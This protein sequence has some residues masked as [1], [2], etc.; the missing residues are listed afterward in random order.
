MR[1]VDVIVNVASR[2]IDKPF[3]YE[4]PA[5]DEFSHLEIGHLVEV[6]FGNRTVPGFVVDTD[7]TPAVEGD[8]K[9]IIQIISGPHFGS[10]AV[11]IAQ[12][13]SDYYAS[14]LANCLNLFTPPLGRNWRKPPKRRPRIDE[15]LPATDAP[16]HERLTEG[17]IAA[18]D[19]IKTLAGGETLL[20]DG[21]T[22][23]GKT[24][25]YLR[26]IEELI[27][28]GKSAIVLVPEISL[29]PQTVGRFRARFGE[30]VAVLH[31]RLTEAQRAYQLSRLS[32]GQSCVVVGPR[33]ALFA[34]LNN[35]GMIVIDEE[36]DGSYK[37][38]SDP[39]YHARKVAQRIA[40][41]TGA[42]VVLG[43]ATPSFET[44]AQ[45]KEGRIAMVAL[46]E[47][48]NAQPLPPVEV[49]DMTEEFDAGNRSMFSRSLQ[50]HLQIVRDE[51]KKAIILLNRRGFAN[52]V[53]CRECGYVP[54]CPS[55]A[56]S[57]TLHA[58]HGRLQCHHCGRLEAMPPS[59]P[60]CSSPYIASFGAGTQKVESELKKLFD[61]WPV[62]RMDA[63]TTSARTGHL[64]QLTA[65]ESLASGVLVGT[66]MIA[67][68]LDYPDV[69]LVGIIAADSSLNIPEYTAAERTYQ[70]LE[71]V[72]GRAGRAEASGHVI[73]QTYQPAH[74]S[75][76]AVTKHDRSVVL[77]SELSA[78]QELGYPPFTTMANVVI[79]SLDEKEAAR[80][81]EVIGDALKVELPPSMRILGP[82]PCALAK[83]KNRY[84]NHILIKGARADV[85]GPLIMEVLK[86]V[87]TTPTTRVTVD[88]DPQNLS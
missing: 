21:V 37:Q 51:G 12:W 19:A 60:Q 41:Q 5:G 24:E 43:S 10:A 29:T 63:D 87:P 33:S 32:S 25:V 53:L 61:D 3:S 67:K 64:E 69:T 17:Q 15:D 84:R 85:L 48:V 11:R 47:R 74:P 88:I 23:S 20:L 65:F 1:Y 81:A 68:G 14:P 40:A 8:L 82:V 30:V 18:L 57:L 34:P 39:R 49:V 75:I 28:E 27:A 80:H 13:M 4:V 42:K 70:L 83:L 7:V 56:T 35:L 79:S 72:A 54:M 55:C 31:S 44:L 22:G 45:V 52:F 73:I 46:P 62:V 2:A 76:R 26:A 66:Q 50:K 36:H 86:S 9:P 16:R 38:E 58:S 71:Q 6:P 78:R 59:C 77:A